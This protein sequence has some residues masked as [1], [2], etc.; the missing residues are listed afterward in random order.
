MSSTYTTF[1]ERFLGTI[2]RDQP[3]A[4]TA[5]GV[6]DWDDQLGDFSVAGWEARLRHLADLERG[7]AGLDLG[8]LSPTQRVDRQLALGYCR[9]G[10]ATMSARPPWKMD[11]GLYASLPADSLFPLLLREFAP[12]PLRARSAL[13]RLRLVPAVLAEGR[14]T[15]ER[16]ARIHTE[17]AIEMAEGSRRFLE[18]VIPPVAERTPELSGALR[19]A[20]GAAG[21]ALRDFGRFLREEL[22]PRSTGEFALGRA[23]FDRILAEEHALDLNAEDL[24]RIGREAIRETKREMEAVAARIAP[25]VPWPVLVERAKRDHVPSPQGVRP[26]YEA[27]M[28]RARQFVIYHELVTMPE[29]ERLEVIDT[30]EFWRPLLPYAAYMPAGPFEREQQ[31]FF[32]VTPV[33][34]TAP[35]EQQ[36]KQ[37]RGHNRYHIEVVA[38]HEAYPGHHL[39]LLHANAHPSR[40]RRFFMNTV[41]CEGWALYCE[42]MMRELGFNEG[43]L[44]H[45]MQLRDQ[46]WRACRVVADAG[47]HAGGMTVEEAARLLVEEARIEEPNAAAE[48][49]RY[50]MSPTQPMS[51]LIGKRE[52][53]RLRDEYR[54]RTAGRFTLRGFHDALLSHGSIPPAHVGREMLGGAA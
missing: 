14:R 53:L 26:A 3:A 42:Q 39:Q 40:L 48:V 25:G 17:T 8:L 6:H 54:A 21:E 10:Q 47:L 35:P 1:A 41:F 34:A 23:L 30:P 38:L 46:L 29:E 24:D 13:A 20:A 51:Y 19:E 31:G 49:R 36:A 28:E 45:L 43:G 27:A 15:L 12:L 11:P 32:F 52:L 16:P 4:A 33:D 9:L 22:L 18:V 5:M 50:T 2:W 7:A 37:L 44:G